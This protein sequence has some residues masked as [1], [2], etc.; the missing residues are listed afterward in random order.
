MKNV[1]HLT[2]PKGL[3]MAWIGKKAAER[4]D[5]HNNNQELQQN[6]NHHWKEFCK[7]RQE[8]NDL[9]ERGKKITEDQKEKL[10]I[11]FVGPNEKWNYIIRPNG[12]LIS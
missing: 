11:E 12:Q 1:L 6:I 3:G 7:L 9:Y 4:W 8:L 2:A 5:S 10:N